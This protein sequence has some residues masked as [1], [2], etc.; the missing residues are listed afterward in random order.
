MLKKDKITQW[1]LLMASET[2]AD[3]DADLFTSAKS[4]EDYLPGED[5]TCFGCK[6]SAWWKQT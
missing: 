6:D 1:K 3:E 4:A 5:E 2:V